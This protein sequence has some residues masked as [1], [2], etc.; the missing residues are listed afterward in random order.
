[1]EPPEEPAQPRKPRKTAPKAAS[2]AKKRP[3]KQAAKSAKQPIPRPAKRPTPGLAKPGTQPAAPSIP[4]EAAIEPAAAS[5]ID[6]APTSVIQAAVPELTAPPAPAPEEPES[7]PR[8]IWTAAATA[9]AV[10]DA[11]GSEGDLPAVGSQTGLVVSLDGPASSGKSSVGA[12]A[13]ARLGYRFCDT[14]LLY[15]AVTWLALRREV[16]PEDSVGLVRLVDEVRLVAD[17]GGRLR[18]VTVDGVDVT[19]AVHSPDVD[20]LVSAVSR[21]PDVR[22]ALLARQRRIA[23]SGRIIMAGRDIGTVVL[24]DADLKLYLDA[25]LHERALRRAQERELDPGSHQAREVLHELRR[26]DTIDSTRPVAPLRI[27]E[28]AL[29]LHTDGNT[30]D[31]TVELV[32]RAVQATEATAG[33]AAGRR[34]PSAERNA[35]GSGR[36]AAAPKPTPI[37]SRNGPLRSVGGLIFRGIAGAIVRIQIEGDLASIPRTGPLIVAANHASSADPVLIGAFLPKTLGR[38][39]NWLG[40]RELVEMPVIGWFM[41]QVPIHPVDRATAD[42]EAFRVAMRILESGNIL[43]VFPEGTRSKDGVLQPAKDGAAVLALR[44]GAPVL[45]VAVGDSDLMWP[46]HS[47][48]PRPGRTVTVRYG[49]P[50]RLADELSLAPAGMDRRAAKE[51]ATALIMSRIAELL[52]ERQRGPYGA[53]ASGTPGRPVGAPEQASDDASDDAGAEGASEVSTSA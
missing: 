31:Q 11:G 17:D 26:R 39:L 13:A 49:R 28:G 50:F 32:V 53:P 25:T 23:E 45:P 14:G 21:V 9:P 2:Q 52:P 10:E 1:V 43:A 36:R 20:A 3:A 42:L 16:W 46:K 18:H 22:A 7:T 15:R 33:D 29:V 51:A 5:V 40:K 4:D 34:R 47:R 8:T 24:P 30:F 19:D 44:S 48:L 38:P 35:A 41:R 12:A 6:P 27:P 37:A